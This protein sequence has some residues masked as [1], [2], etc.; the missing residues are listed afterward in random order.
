M[1]LGMASKN[2]DDLPRSELN[3]IAV[4]LAASA[5][6]AHTGQTGNLQAASPGMTMK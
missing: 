6:S 4:T 5:A 3:K 1:T 2:N